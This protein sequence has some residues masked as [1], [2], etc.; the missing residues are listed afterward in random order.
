MAGA[1]RSRPDQGPQGPG[2]VE[3]GVRTGV[4]RWQAGAMLARERGSASSINCRAVSLVSV[5]VMGLRQAARISGPMLRWPSVH[6]CFCSARTAPARR[7]MESRPGNKPTSSPEGCP[8][9]PA[10]KSALALII[11][12]GCWLPRSVPRIGVT[13]EILASGY[14]SGPAGGPGAGGSTGPG[15]SLGRRDGSVLVSWCRAA[16]IYASR[17]ARSPRPTASSRRS[18]SA[19][20][21][22]R[23]PAGRGCAGRGS[24]AFSALPWPG[25]RRG[26][27]A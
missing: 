22:R 15:A 14:D 12:G 26:R 2:V 16:R 23:A 13:A 6:P 10:R 20:G 8:E 4:A 21:A 11:H 17:L 18:S 5:F 19:C 1:A 3:P 27:G 9:P 24:A 7:I 25:R